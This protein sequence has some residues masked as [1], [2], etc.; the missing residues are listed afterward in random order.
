MNGE[1]KNNIINSNINDKI[2]KDITLETNDP[3]KSITKINE[4]NSPILY[5]HKSREMKI[6]STKSSNERIIFSNEN[7]SDSIVQYFKDSAFDNINSMNN[8]KF[9]FKEDVSNVPKINRD[10]YTNL[11]TFSNDNYNK[12]NII[13]II[14]I[15]E[16]KFLNRSFFKFIS[17]A[18]MY[19]ETN[20]KESFQKRIKLYQEEL[21]NKNTSL[22]VD[23]INHILKKFPINIKAETFRKISLH[24]ISQVRKR[25]HSKKSI[26]FQDVNCTTLSNNKY[27]SQLKKNIFQEDNIKYDKLNNSQ[28]DHRYNYDLEKVC[29]NIVTENKID[30]ILNRFDSNHYQ[31]INQTLTN[32]DPSETKNYIRMNKFIN[33]NSFTSKKNNLEKISLIGIYSDDCSINED[34][35]LDNIIENIDAN[36]KYMNLPLSSNFNNIVNTPRFK[37]NKNRIN[38]TEQT[39]Q[40]IDENE[41]NIKENDGKLIITHEENAAN[42]KNIPVPIAQTI[43]YKKRTENSKKLKP[44]IKVSDNNTIVDNLNQ[45][46]MEFMT[47][48]NKI[49]KNQ[50][51]LEKKNYNLIDENSIDEALKLDY[52][53]SNNIINNS[54]NRDYSKNDIIK[55]A[56]P[57]YSLIDLDSILPMS[58]R[59]ESKSKFSI[60]RN[61]LTQILSKDI[62]DYNFNNQSQMLHNK[63]AIV[64]INNTIYNKITGEIDDIRSKLNQ[65]I[66]IRKL[67]KNKKKSEIEKNRINSLINNTVTETIKNENLCTENKSNKKISKCLPPKNK[68]I[69]GQSSHKILNQT[70]IINSK[71]T[72]NISDKIHKM[73]S[74]KC[75]SIP[76]QLKVNKNLKEKN[77]IIPKI[78]LLLFILDKF[79]LPAK[80]IFFVN[81]SLIKTLSTR[82]YQLSIINTQIIKKIRNPEI[83]FNRKFCIKILIKFLKRRLIFYKLF[84]LKKSK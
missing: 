35:Y 72:I 57:K 55:P 11:N 62:D 15:L 73:K 14:K 48:L 18:N 22:F 69:K 31:E 76:L 41:N 58:E 66:K 52:L 17:K 79:L 28:I 32:L 53:N 27:L 25:S 65:I 47:S 56:D 30:L 78:K 64:E 33:E 61:N 46:E 39:N 80:R 38:K 40:P 49:Y 75:S 24:S 77:E 60:K 50:S 7:C 26:K 5:E 68:V 84:F 12:K 37:K 29:K 1:N 71:E 21:I 8:Y 2:E 6:A 82:T 16:Q 74:K 43:Y 19:S 10:L 36:Q 51:F 45:K 3:I 44:S 23:I 83:E 70:T 42:E 54:T 34:N 20:L 59:F 81:L 9:G 13:S 67:S 63:S 4:K